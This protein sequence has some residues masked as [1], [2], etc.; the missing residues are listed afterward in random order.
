MSGLVAILIALH[1]L[2]KRE[3]SIKKLKPMLII[4]GI[5]TVTIM[6]YVMH[7]AWATRSLSPHDLLYGSQDKISLYEPIELDRN[8]CDWQ[9]GE[10]HEGDI[11][12][13]IPDSEGVS[14]IAQIPWFVSTSSARG[15]SIIQDISF[16]FGGLLLWLLLDWRVLP[17]TR[18]FPKYLL[19]GLWGMYSFLWLISAKGIPWY[20]IAWF[21][22]ALIFYVAWWDKRRWILIIPLIA[23]FMGTAFSITNMIHRRAGGLFYAAG[24][25]TKVHYENQIFFNK[26]LVDTF[27]NS[28]SGIDKNII[29][30]G[31]TYLDFIIN[32]NRKRVIGD[33]L[34]FYFNCLYNERDKDLTLS[35]LKELDIGFF[36]VNHTLDLGVQPHFVDF[37]DFANSK[38]ELLM[39]EPELTIYRVP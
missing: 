39:Q 6:P 29:M 14:L 20:G 30:G 33:R 1:S 7:N 36:I 25:L 12:N 17:N 24:G 31:N 37:V 35:R 11:S 15:N 23:I 21:P 19:A 18:K 10:F 22:L 28:P 3:I 2:L 32:N 26:E 8:Q 4:S 5:I 38:L 13:Y 27:I 34:F 16:A 9:S